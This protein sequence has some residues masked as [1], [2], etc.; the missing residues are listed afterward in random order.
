MNTWLPGVMDL[1][2]RLRQVPDAWLVTVVPTSA[3]TV[4]L[5]DAQPNAP[6]VSVAITVTG[7][8]LGLGGA[9]IWPLMTPVVLLIVRPVGRPVADQVN[10]CCLVEV[11][12]TVR[13]SAL[14]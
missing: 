14:N 11:P 9:V 12:L 10:G 8:G 6:V 5:K 1:P 4:Q 3:R 13:L 7:K 2:R